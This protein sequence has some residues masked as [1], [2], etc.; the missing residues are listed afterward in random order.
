[1]VSSDHLAPGETGRIR[2]TVNTA[3][4]KGRL[5]KSVQVL[6]NDPARP[7]V[8]LS[9]KATVKEILLIKPD[10]SPLLENIPSPSN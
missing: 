10:T 2:T 1:M 7:A 3:G 9:L 5:L 8:A 6:S 4:R